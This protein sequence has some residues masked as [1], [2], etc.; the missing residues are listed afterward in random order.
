MNYII[1]IC[2]TNNEKPLFNETSGLYIL[3]K[4]THIFVAKM[5]QGVDSCERE[6][7]PMIVTVSFEEIYDVAFYGAL[8]L[9]IIHSSF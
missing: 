3:S 5:F 1:F 8:A 4:H 7:D 6:R 2:N 9:K